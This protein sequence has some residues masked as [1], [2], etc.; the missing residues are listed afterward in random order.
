MRGYLRL[1]RH[2]RPVKQ[3]VVVIEH[4]L[5]LLGLDIGRKQ[6]FELLRPCRAPGK[7]RAQHLAKRRLR[8]DGA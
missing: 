3:K 1:G 5:R 4:I 8:V 2:L 7:G 6:L